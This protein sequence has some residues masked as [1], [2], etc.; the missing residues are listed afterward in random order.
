MTADLHISHF[1]YSCFAQNSCFADPT[2][3]PVLLDGRGRP[4]LQHSSRP[5]CGTASCQASAWLAHACRSWSRCSVLTVRSARW[6]CR[7]NLL[8]GA[9]H[10]PARH[11]P[12]AACVKVPQPR[13]LMPRGLLGR[14]CRSLGVAIITSPMSV[15]SEGTKLS[16]VDACT[17]HAPAPPR[18]RPCIMAAQIPPVACP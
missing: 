12:H 5:T 6:P 2:E 7:S 4:L 10:V 17:P 18:T 8:P 15:P 14:A 1:P 9:F 16:E 11:L 13:L 3:R